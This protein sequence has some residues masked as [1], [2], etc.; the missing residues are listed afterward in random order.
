[1]TI[2]K[3][4]KSIYDIHFLFFHFFLL[5]YKTAYYTFSF[6]VTLGMILAGVH[7]P[8]TLNKVEEILLMVCILFMNTFYEHF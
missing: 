4:G 3:K 1:M 5:Q 6:P 2:Y 7:D 8:E